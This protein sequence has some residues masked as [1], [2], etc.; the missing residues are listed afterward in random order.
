[1]NLAEY[2]GDAMSLG[3]R[4]KHA[5]NAFTGKDQQ[6][7]LMQDLGQSYSVRQD[8]IPL[9]KGVERSIVAS[10]YTRIAIDVSAVRIEHARTDDS[11]RYLDRI[12]SGLNY[13][14]NTEANI[15]QTSKDFIQ[16]LV[17]TL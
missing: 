4:I 15:D 13:C 8:R 7:I 17:E 12:D 2:S 5:W 9:R 10:I 14:L 6:R 3:Q 11:K 16:D 1:M